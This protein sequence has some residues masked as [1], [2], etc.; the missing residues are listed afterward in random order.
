M[1]RDGPEPTFVISNFSVVYRSVFKIVVAPLTIKLE[2]T[3]K[4]PLIVAVPL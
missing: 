2:L 3:T 4:S 1:L